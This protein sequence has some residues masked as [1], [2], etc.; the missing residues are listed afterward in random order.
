MNESATVKWS[1]LLWAVAVAAGVT[2]TSLAVTEI[3]IDGALEAGVWANIGLRALVYT[4]AALLILAFSQGRRWARTS[5]VILL[6]VI[7][8]ASMVVSAAAAMAGGESF[9]QAF[10]SDGDLSGAFLAVRL[11]H[12]AAVLAA[13]ALMFTPSAN[14]HF[15]K[16]EPESSP[17]EVDR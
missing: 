10:G 15:R 2:E 11:T 13:T 6:S 12:I 1:A 4:G 5:L 8:L 7:G 16:R 17:L 9:T 14:R 3:A